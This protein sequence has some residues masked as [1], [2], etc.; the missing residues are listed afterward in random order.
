VTVTDRKWHEVVTVN[1]TTGATSGE[2][3]L[4]DAIAALS[5]SG[6]MS[7]SDGIT[8]DDGEVSITFDPHTA[9]G[10]REGVL[11]WLDSLGIE[12]TASFYRWQDDR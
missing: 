7:S 9:D 5:V 11:R 6:G 12:Y 10:G 3:F 4:N 2:P 1:A 8:N